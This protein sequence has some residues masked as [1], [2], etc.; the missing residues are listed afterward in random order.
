MARYIG[1]VVAPRR[2]RDGIWRASESYA[3]SPLFRRA[4]DYCLRHHDEWYVLSASHGLLAPQQVVGPG[5]PTWGGLSPAERSAWGR[6]A[7][8]ALRERRDRSGDELVFVLYGPRQHARL[9]GRI[10]PSLKIELPLAG[11]NA[12][13]RARWFDERL[14][15]AP[16]RLLVERTPP[17]PPLA[18]PPSAPAPSRSFWRLRKPNLSAALALVGAKR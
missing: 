9:L 5:D 1:L 11:K 17:N 10:D 4:R 13:E 18:A 2:Q 3:A 15:V 14:G 16:R 12:R 7:A 8:I 6:R